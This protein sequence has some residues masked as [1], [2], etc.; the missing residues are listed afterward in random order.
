MTLPQI[1]SGDVHRAISC[2][3]AKARAARAL[4]MWHFPHVERTAANEV[5]TRSARHM[6]RRGRLCGARAGRLTRAAQDTSTVR[7]RRMNIGRADRAAGPTRGLRGG[8][9]THD[10]HLFHPAIAGLPPDR[11]RTR[12]DRK[13]STLEFGRRRQT[14][15]WREV[16][17]NVR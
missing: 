7:T 3:T 15:I 10:R 11:S 6:R 13:R 5:E 1:R 14:A 17:H 12:S 9:A 4:T 2:R 16:V 8:S